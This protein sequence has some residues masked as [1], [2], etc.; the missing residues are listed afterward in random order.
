MATKRT[1]QTM[2]EKFQ[3]MVER[4]RK[5]RRKQ[6]AYWTKATADAEEH[7]RLYLEFLARYCKAHRMKGLTTRQE[8]RIQGIKKPLLSWL[9]VHIGRMTLAERKEYKAIGFL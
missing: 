4:R 3:R 7:L 9:T 8:I 5:R 1:R 2:E 6:I